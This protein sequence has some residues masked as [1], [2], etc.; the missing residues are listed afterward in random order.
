M[1]HA[2]ELKLKTL[3]KRCIPEDE[4]LHGQINIVKFL[5][6][7]VDAGLLTALSA[8]NDGVNIIFYRKLALEELHE[9]LLQCRRP[10]S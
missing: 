8:R 6:A 5:V 10:S 1:F 4:Q 3:Q 7:T 9:P 2:V